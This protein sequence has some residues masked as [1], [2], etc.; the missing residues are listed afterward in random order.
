MH[1]YGERMKRSRPLVAIAAALLL[2]PL[3][4]CS[5]IS[6]GAADGSAGS[7]VALQ[8]ADLTPEMMSGDMMRDAAVPG[9]ERSIVRTGSMTLEV[10][11]SKEAVA[12]IADVAK[13]LG[14]SVVSQSLSSNGGTSETGEIAIRVPS[15]K[16]DAAFTQLS[17]V[18]TVQSENRTADDVTEQHV[19]L[20]ARVASLESSVK[21]LTELMSNATST[22]DLLEAESA[23]SQRQQELDGLR[24]QLESLEGQ[25]EQANIWVSVHEASALPGGG[26]KNF[27]DAIVVGFASIG[28]FGAGALIALGV[29][30][31][32]LVI[33]GVIA[34]AIV[35]P[36]RRSRRHRR[37]KLT[38]APAETD[39][40][41]D[42]VVNSDAP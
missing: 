40:A 32:W 26:P 10:E 17:K 28:A 39:S 15:D 3:A 22:S 1:P 18:G 41:S 9:T 12:T 19:D 35:I 25:I 23:L 13:S 37:E 36:V 30:L 5:S 33:A 4:A 38:A 31:P 6:G 14:G 29:A 2:V 8:S 42:S 21:R 7:D 24:A 11:S 20:N 27:W 16:L 34:A